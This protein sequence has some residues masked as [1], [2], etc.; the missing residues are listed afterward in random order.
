MPEA[1]DPATSVPDDAVV[2]GVDVG[3]TNVK[4]GLVDRAG[5]VTDRFALLTADF[6]DPRRLAAALARE[7]AAR[8]EARPL[9]GVGIGAPNGNVYRGTVEHPP[10]LPWPGVTPLAAW[11]AEAVGAPCRLTNDA[12]AAALGEGL[13]GAARGLRDYL[14]VTLGTGL[15]SGI[16][17]NG[18]MVYGHDGFAAELGHVIVAPGGRLCGCGRRGCLE[19][20]ASATGLVRTYR[21]LAP[22]APADL[23]AHHVFQRAEAGEAAAE[24]AFERMAETLGLAL[25][26]SVAY[27]EPAAIFLAG[28]VAAAGERLFEPVRR[29]FEAN[30]FTLYRGKTAILPSGLPASDAAVLGAASLIWTAH[31]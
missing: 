1:Q 16:V 22:D 14:F 18:E 19:Q 4:G 24:A 25:A 26:N 15:G 30:L 12:N 31:A 8:V 2:A 20:Y 10:N 27:T 7:V 3:G 9:L 23:D 29:H 21:E 13:F 17:A 5:R 28:G 11:I 6:G